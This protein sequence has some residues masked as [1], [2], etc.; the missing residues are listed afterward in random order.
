MTPILDHPLR[1][2]L[3]NELHARPIPS[4]DAPCH[5]AYLAIT[6]VADGS[7]SEGD[8]ERRHLL[9]LLDRYGAQHPAPGAT[10]YF[11][12]IGQLKL[13]WEQ[14]TEFVTY[15]LFGSGVAD[16]PFDGTTFGL[17]PQDWLAKAPG[18]R[19]S[20]AL[21]RI[22]VDQNEED[23][24]AK[25]RK[26]FVSESLAVNVM[27]SGKVVVAGDFRIDPAGHTR[28]AAFVSRETRAHEIGQVIQRTCEIETYKAIAMQGFSMVRELRD[29]LNNIEGRLNELALE[30]ASDEVPAEKTLANLLQQSAELEHLMAKSSFRFAGTAAYASIVWDRVNMMKENRFAERQTFSEFMIRRFE[31]AMRTV[32]SA[33]TR[34]NN[35]SQRARRVAEL[36]RTRV[37]VERSAQNQKLLENMNRRAD[38]QLQLQKTVEG[39]SVVAISYYAL[40]L[41]GYFLMPVAK[42]AELDK[43]WLMA[44]LM[45]VVVASVW[46][47]VRNIRNSLH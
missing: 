42:A 8:A 2:K 36:L 34:L 45:P 23:I 14:H 21:F 17:F 16:R 9:Q 33:E 29:R 37:D 3:A 46:W 43:V 22:E 41:A 25:L 19:L 7:M 1:Y 11:G 10:H 28:F 47:V 35:M 27:S 32:K 38:M 31:P 20:S 4:V 13:K 12:E 44:G 5:A 6:R 24:R 18:Q 40:N 30:M 26:W 15:T 39:L